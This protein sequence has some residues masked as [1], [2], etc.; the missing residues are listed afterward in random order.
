M[1]RQAIIPVRHS[2]CTSAGMPNLPAAM[3]CRWAL[4][5]ARAPAAGSTGALPNGRVSWPT[6]FA[7]RVC[8]SPCRAASD[9]RGATSPSASST[10]I[11]M[12]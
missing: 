4:A 3:I 8:Q 10:P 1:A 6:P 9:C 11:Q 2:S 5:S 7:I 12:A